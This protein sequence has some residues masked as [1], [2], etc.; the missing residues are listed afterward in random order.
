VA[1]EL[2][3]ADEERHREELVKLTFEMSKHLTTLSV[4]ATLVVLAIYRELTFGSALLGVTLS[5]FGL[6]IV[7]SIGLMVVS[8]SY[9]TH[10]GRQD[11][12]AVDP[13]LM[14]ASAAASYI[15]VAGVGAFMLFLRDLPLWAL[16]FVIVALLLLARSV[17]AYFRRQRASESKG[18]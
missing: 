15:F 17:R 12:V 9:F 11:R 5:L 16:A 4:A 18:E 8:M 7:V 6:T 1:D 13:L 2:E 14:W 3:R 10:R